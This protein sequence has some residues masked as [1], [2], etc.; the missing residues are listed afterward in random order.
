MLSCLLYVV[1]SYSHIIEESWGGASLS[2]LGE[3]HVENFKAQ[4]TV[5][6]F[7]IVLSPT[8]MLKNL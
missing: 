6:P 1:R 7:N 3:R 4:I 8:V 5:F 2:F